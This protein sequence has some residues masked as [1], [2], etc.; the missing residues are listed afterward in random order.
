MV[1]HVSLGGLVFSVLA[2]PG[3]TLGAAFSRN[4]SMAFTCVGGRSGQFSSQTL[5]SSRMPDQLHCVLVLEQSQEN[6]SGTSRPLKAQPQCSHI[7]NPFSHI[8]YQSAFLGWPRLSGWGNSLRSSRR[9]SK[10]IRQWVC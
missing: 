2:V 9:R 6:Q 4:F 3:L 1:S 10:V 8:I 7:I 5:P